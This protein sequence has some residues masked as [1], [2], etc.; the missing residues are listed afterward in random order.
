MA[1]GGAF[2]KNIQDNVDK[3][4]TVRFETLGC[5]LNQI[6]SEATAKYFIDAGFNVKVEGVTSASPDDLSTSLCIINTCTVTQK[7][8][9]KA[10]RI[11]RLCLKKYTNATVLVTGCYAQLA[12]AEINSID[13]RVVV[14]GGQIKSRLVEVPGLLKNELYKSEINK[15]AD[16]Q[17]HDYSA[18]WSP[19]EFVN[20]INENVVN[21]PQAK[22]TFPEDSFKLSTSSFI[23]H[24]RASLKIQ[25][26][27]NNNCSYCAIHMARGHSVSIDVQTAIDRVVEL[28]KAGQ[29]EVVLT[30]VNIGQYKG[31]Y[32][33]EFLNFSQLLVKLLENTSSINFRIS[34]L[35]P[36]IVDDEFCSVISND[37]VRPSFHLSVQ[38]G[39]DKILQ[40]MNRAYKAADV[41]NAC[42]LIRSVKP[43]AFIACDII[44]GFPGEED[45][46]FE[47]TMALCRRCD[48]YGFTVSLILNVLVLLL[49]L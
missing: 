48:F 41:V 12:A 36:E 47:D 38:S 30:T 10:R 39:S 8:E 24:S 3:K 9:Q 33:G 28:E 13:P 17:R 46:D 49:L 37:R 45:C 25:D 29:D 19:V 16:G 1:E 22:L 11:I 27:C 20:I 40:S 26:G 2:N 5:R 43:D 31:A 34:S 21:K 18:G 15:K 44:T 7:A 32:K 23:A 4:L 14:V 42:D 35:Y 6:E